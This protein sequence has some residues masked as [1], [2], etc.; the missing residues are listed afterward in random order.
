SSL[1]LRDPNADNTL[2]EAWAASDETGKTSWQTFTY[3]ATAT[4]PSG[5]GQ[6]S[7]WNDF[8]FGLLAEG[9]CLIDDIS[10]L[11]SPTNNP[12]Q[13][14]ANGGFE[15]GLTG[16]RAI[17]THGASRVEVDPDN[18]GNHVLHIIATGPQEHMHNH[19]EGT[20]VSNK[21]ITASREYQISFRARWVAGN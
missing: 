5:S 7:Q 4:I 20:Y 21:T 16:W 17:G 6:P 2:P 13:F 1:E 3:K 9:E 14:I 18:P 12:V 8:V 19:I 15:N 11:E 10:V